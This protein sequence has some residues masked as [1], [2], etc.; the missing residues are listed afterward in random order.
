M[1]KLTSLAT[2]FVLGCAAIGFAAPSMSPKMNIVQKASA[3]ADC[4]TLV[5]AVKAAG[6]VETLSGPGPF[7]VFAPTDEAFPKTAFRHSRQSRET[8]E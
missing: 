1:M 2:V 3:T 6:L 7:T 4:S 5:T 8:R